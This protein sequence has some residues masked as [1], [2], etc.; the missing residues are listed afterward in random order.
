[1]ALNKP[2]TSSSVLVH[3]SIPR[4]ASLGNDGDKSGDSLKCAITNA[5]VNPWWKVDLGAKARVLRVAVISRSDHYHYRI[6]PFYI[7]VGDK[8]A[9]GG[10]ENAYCAKNATVVMGAMKSFDCPSNTIGRYVS[11]NLN[12][13]EHLQIGEVEAYG[14]YV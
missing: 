5:D 9:D 11:I 8:D 13:T 12:K 3:G 10:V 2:A 1:M 14:V 4:V 6:N 7:R